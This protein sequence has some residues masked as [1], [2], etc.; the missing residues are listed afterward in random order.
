MAAYSTNPLYSAAIS[1]ATLE[2]VALAASA[3][4]VLAEEASV[5]S[6]VEEVLEAAEPVEDFEQLKVQFHKPFRGL[7]SHNPVLTVNVCNELLV[8]GDEY[9][10]LVFHDLHHRVVAQL[11]KTF[12]YTN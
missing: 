6:V 3:E 5:A 2:A 11:Q 9:L 12:A 10:F 1:G 4:A 7:H 8:H